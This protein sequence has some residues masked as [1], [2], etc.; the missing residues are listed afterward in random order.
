[1]RCQPALITL[2]WSFCLLMSAQALAA[3]APD[4]LPSDAEGFAFLEGQWQVSHRRLKEPLTGRTDWLEFESKARFFT[5]LD[6]LVSVEEL[7]GA[8]GKPF[9]AAVRSFDRSTRLWSDRWLPARSGLLGGAVTGKFENGVAVFAS[10]EDWEG[11]RLISRGTWQRISPTEVTWQ[12]EAS[13]DD[14]KTWELNWFMRF[15]RVVDQP[16]PLR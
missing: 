2:F 16:Y 10:E 1:M 12:Q 6:G 4:S 11:K 14:G 15:Q 7:Y 8:D 5:L 9:G 13:I 3:P